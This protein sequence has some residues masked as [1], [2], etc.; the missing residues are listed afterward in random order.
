MIRVEDRRS[1]ACDIEQAFGELERDPDNGHERAIHP[2]IDHAIEQ[3]E[4][5]R[6]CQR[7]EPDDRD[8]G[9]GA[10]FRPQIC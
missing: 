5:A 3:K 10:A 8:Q 1:I 4:I 9:P 2:E 7:K 6:S